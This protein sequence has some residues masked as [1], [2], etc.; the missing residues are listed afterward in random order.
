M[1][2]SKTPWNRH[3]I[4]GLKIISN[5]ILTIFDWSPEGLGSNPGEGINVCKCILLSRHGVTQNSRRA[6]SPHVRLVKGEEKA[7]ES[8]DY[9]RLILQTGQVVQSPV[10]C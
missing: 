5:G 10:W 9:P 6:A 7:S 2:L 4:Q 1:V 3:I 8:L